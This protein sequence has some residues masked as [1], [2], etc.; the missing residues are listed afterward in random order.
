MYISSGFFWTLPKGQLIPWVQGA[1]KALLDYV[2]KNKATTEIPIYNSLQA[3]LTFIIIIT[4][5]TFRN[6]ARLLSFRSGL[7]LHP[8]ISSQ[9]KAPQ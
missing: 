6:Y 5:S 9:A 7:P 4:S 1:C 2:G 8:L 3:M